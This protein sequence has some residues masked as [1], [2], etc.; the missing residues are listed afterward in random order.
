MLGGYAGDLALIFG[1]RGGVFLAGGIVR[2]LGGLFDAAGFRERFAAKPPHQALLESIPTF[3][4][5][6]PYPALLG[7]SAYL[8]QH[9]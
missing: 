4:I 8:A 6:H 5:A 2:K 7:L 1:A 9:G 3:H